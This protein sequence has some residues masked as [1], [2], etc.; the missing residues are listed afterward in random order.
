MQ[1]VKILVPDWGLKKAL[2]TTLGWS[3]HATSDVLPPLLAAARYRSSM[4]S[5]YCCLECHFMQ[6]YL[7]WLH[8]VWRGRCMHQNR[9]QQVRT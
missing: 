8:V 3:M 2:L 9:A 4:L 7:D 5:Y 1:V 6:L